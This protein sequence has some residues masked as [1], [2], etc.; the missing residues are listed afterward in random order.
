[1]IEET[2]ATEEEE[3]KIKPKSMNRPKGTI[4]NPFEFFQIQE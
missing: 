2:Y 3:V 1:V 4:K